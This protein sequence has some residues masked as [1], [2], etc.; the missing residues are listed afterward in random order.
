MPLALLWKQDFTH[1]SRF[2]VRAPRRPGRLANDALLLRR[3]RSW[4]RR[5]RSR[6][7]RIHDSLRSTTRLRSKHLDRGELVSFNCFKGNGRGRRG[8][9]RRSNARKDGVHRRDVW[10]LLLHDLTQLLPCWRDDR[11]K[12]GQQLGDVLHFAWT[13]EKRRQD[14]LDSFYDLE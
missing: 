4:R 11:T 10:R 2:F 14:L 12:L 8:A 6:R 7:W 9:S 13:G 5:G 1:E 3:R